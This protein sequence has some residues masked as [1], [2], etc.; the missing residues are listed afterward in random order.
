ML[1]MAAFKVEWFARQEKLSTSSLKEM[2]PKRGTPSQEAL[3]EAKKVQLVLFAEGVNKRLAQMG[4]DRAAGLQVD[5]S[6]VHEGD[7]G[8]I[9]G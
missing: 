8:V 7:P 5:P 9:H 4:A 6:V 1:T 2:L 3:L